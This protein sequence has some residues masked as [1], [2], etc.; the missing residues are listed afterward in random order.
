MSKMKVEKVE[1]GE[2]EKLEDLQLEG[3]KI[4]Q[5]KKGFCFGIDSILLSEFAKEIKNGAKVLDL[6]TGTGIIATLLCGKTQLGEIVG[7]E[8]QKDVYEMAKKSI[9]LNHLEERFKIINEDI[10][11]LDKILEK[12]SFDVI[13]TNP[14]YKKKGTGLKNEEEKKTIS[15]HETTATLEDFIKVSKNLLKDNGEFYMVHRA[16]RL[17]DILSIMRNYKIEPKILHFVCANPNIES[18]LILVKGI[19]YAKPSLKISLLVLGLNE[20]PLI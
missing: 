19:K 13:V 15:R 9:K 2:S 8:K 4:I 10:I 11:N 5:D 12:N 17:V 14:P 1:L 16:D 7:I 18:K 20:T 6:G 3:L